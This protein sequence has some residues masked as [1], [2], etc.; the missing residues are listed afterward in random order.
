MSCFLNLGCEDMTSR[1]DF[2][3]CPFCGYY[4][5]KVA[6]SR[7]SNNGDKIRRRRECLSCK[8]RFTT[9]ESVETIP[10]IVVKKDK[11]REEFDRE[12]IIGGLLKACANRPVSISDIEKIADDIEQVLQNSLEKEFPSSLI[13]EYT[14]E[15]LKQIDEVSYVRFASVYKQFKDINTFMEELKKLLCED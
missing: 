15:R 3:K 12:K 7:P 8:K 4:D 11:S 10:V 14:M 1:G 13:G 2:V 6:D 9:F 5:S